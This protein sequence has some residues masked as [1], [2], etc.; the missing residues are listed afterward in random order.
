MSVHYDSVFYYQE[1]N[2]NKYENS[3]ENA[4]IKD[5][6]SPTSIAYITRLKQHVQ[7]NPNID[8]YFFGSVTNFTFFEKM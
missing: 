4:K 7:H 1:E 6:L 5:R 2:E 3:S 8:I